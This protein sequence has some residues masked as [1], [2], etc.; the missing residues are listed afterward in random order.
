MKLMT[1][2]PAVQ[3]DTDR[4]AGTATSISNTQSNE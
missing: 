1:A 4:V 2:N 3:F